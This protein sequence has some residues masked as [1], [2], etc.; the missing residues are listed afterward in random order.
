MCTFICYCRRK[1]KIE[2]CVFVAETMC[3]PNVKNSPNFTTLLSFSMET[4]LELCDDPDSNIRLVADESLN[5]I[6]RVSE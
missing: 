6:I 1:K 3:T 2:L 5:R 4:L